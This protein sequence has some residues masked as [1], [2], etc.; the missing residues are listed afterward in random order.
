MEKAVHHWEVAAIGG[1]PV[2][3]H[4]LALCEEDNGNMERAVKHYIIAANLG[5][6]KSMK[7]LWAMFKDGDISK[8]DLAATLRSHQ[9]ALDAMKSPERDLAE[10]IQK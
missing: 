2:A 1:H 4:A 5:Y 8:E 3:R 10:T 7:T 6:E 9:A